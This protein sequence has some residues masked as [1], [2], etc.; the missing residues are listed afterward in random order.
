MSADIDVSVAL[1]YVNFIG[2]GILARILL[3]SLQSIYMVDNFLLPR[4]FIHS[5]RFVG[6]RFVGLTAN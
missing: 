1:S 3:E 6:F 4:T 2:D 5:F